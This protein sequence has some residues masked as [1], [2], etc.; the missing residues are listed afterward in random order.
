MSY[1]GLVDLAKFRDLSN[2][3]KYTL[4]VFSEVCQRASLRQLT[5]AKALDTQGGRFEVMSAIVD[6]GASVP[7]FHPETAAC[8]EM[9]ESE[10][11][12]RGAEYEIANGD[13]LPCRGQKRIAVCTVKGH[14]PRLRIPVC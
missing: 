2:T 8:Y 7:V 4:K 14:S 3:A 10:A 5:A 12:R 13:V 1:S 9:T 11:S 6:S